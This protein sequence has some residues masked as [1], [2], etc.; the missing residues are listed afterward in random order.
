MSS[1]LSGY[2]AKASSSAIHMIER[3]YALVDK[4]PFQAF[5]S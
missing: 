5:A 2:P 4:V 1:S 3:K